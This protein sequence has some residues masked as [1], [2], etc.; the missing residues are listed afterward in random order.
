MNGP[1]RG[2]VVCLVVSL[3]VA[4]TSPAG[5]I[6][7]KS[8]R[9]TRALY[10][11]DTA[12]DVGDSITIVI[13]EHSKIENE[14]N[15]KME[16][17]SSRKASLTGNF[18]LIDALDKLTGKLF[19]LRSPDLNFDASAENKF[20][21]GA[22]YDTDRTM[23][24]EI[25]AVVE[26]ILPNGNLVVLGQRQRMVAGDVQ[27][28]QVSGVVRPSD[29]SFANSVNSKKIADFRIVFKSKGRENR[30]TKPG[31]LGRILNVLDPF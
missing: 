16:K 2:V 25:T 23:A 13:E 26:D 8:T 24:D 4:G 21:G 30:F 29:I 7:A 15:R 3:L 27:I 11:D 28:I 6:W 10:T 14:T 9:R 22:D 1:A 12:R 5:S 20:D 17:T 18:D 31:W 19:S